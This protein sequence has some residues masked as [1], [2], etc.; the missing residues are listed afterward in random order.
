MNIY[1]VGIGG[2]GT[3][4]L[5]K[6]YHQR[7]HDVVGSDIGDG[8]YTKNLEKLDIR[9]Y[10]SFDKNHITDGIDLVVHS[11]AINDKNVEI[12]AAQSKKI[13][14]ITYPEAI[15][16]L[17]KKIRTA[18]VC[19]THGK[20][21]TA[22]LLAHA[23]I[24]TKL[25]TT[26]IVG[27]QVIGWDS[28]AYV[29][30]DDCLVI[31]ADE[32][33]NKL[34]LYEPCCVI[35]TSIDYDHPDFF[36]DFNSYKKVFEDFLNRS[37][38]YGCI[39]ACGD[40]PDVVE[41]TK[42]LQKN[43]IYYG[44]GKNNEYQITSRDISETGQVIHVKTMNEEFDLFTRLHGEHNA[45]NALAAWITASRRSNDKEAARIGI[46]KCK[47]TSRRF[48]SRGELGGALLI[49]D[50]A[51]H[52]E[53]IRATLGAAR[54]VFPKKK[55]I[56]AFHP[57]TFTRTK[58]LLT[59]FAQ[60]LDLADQVIVLDIYGSARETKGDVSA[61]SVVD[62]VNKLSKKK[63]QHIPTVHELAPWMKRNLTKKDAFFTIGAGD[64]WQV[65]DELEK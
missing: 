29:G 47:G 11:T 61:M 23:F 32:Y 52:P 65:Y 49:D 57:H 45:K 35:L 26:A 1:I 64:I 5:A 3:S 21:T 25:K 31:E 20:T 53:E 36:P 48:E 55:I 13:N 60:A 40:D 7:G 8:F 51:H 56:V 19:G 38:S 9:V 34:A 58:A 12:Q 4:A 2:A 44:T 16:R 14:T 41:V 28:G 15:G 33:Q 54:E 50:Y 37:Q 18:A 17:T 43:I 62:E 22:A 24:E 27:S 6:V 59:Q 42:K 30:G 63:A 39:V 46:G 10:K